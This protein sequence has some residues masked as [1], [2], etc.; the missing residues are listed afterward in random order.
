VRAR[1]AR[2]QPTE[3]MQGETREAFD[4]RGDTEGLWHDCQVIR[5]LGQNRCVIR[6][7]KTGAVIPISLAATLDSTKAAT[8]TPFR[9]VAAKV[10]LRNYEGEGFSECELE[11]ENCGECFP[12]PRRH[13]R[14]KIGPHRS[15]LTDSMD[16]AVVPSTSNNNRDLVE[17]LSSGLR[18]PCLFGMLHVDGVA[19]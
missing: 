6:L 15:P 4:R 18:D 14:R 16:L 7:L 12:P 9:A 1:C 8:A 19:K 13:K 2:P 3:S 17:L 5:F 11:M 10:V